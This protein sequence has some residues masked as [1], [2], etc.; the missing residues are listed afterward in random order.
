MP[1]DVNSR[2]NGPAIDSFQ[3]LDGDLQRDVMAYLEDKPRAELYSKEDVINAWMTWNG[4]IG[5]TPKIVRLVQQT[6]KDPA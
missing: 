3:M 5:Y 2:I 4:I 1:K 6:Y